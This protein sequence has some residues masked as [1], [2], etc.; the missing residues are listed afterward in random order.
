MIQKLFVYLV[1]ASV[2]ISCGSDFEKNPV[3]NLIRDLSDVPAYSI[4]LHD[5]NVEGT[6]FE[7]YFHQY[8]IV[9]I[10]KNGEPEKTT[11]DWIQVPEE[12]FQKHI[13]NMGMEIVSKSED[14]KL[15]KTAA[16]PGYS[17]FVGNEKYGRWEQNSNGSSFWQFYGQYMFMNSMFNMMAFPARRSYYDTY[18][19]D[20]YGRRPYYG[21]STSTGGRTYG[22]G[23]TYTSRT[24][25]GSNWKQKMT[26]SSFKNRVQNSVSR[27]NSRY[28]GS[29]SSSSGSM[30]SRG[31]GFGK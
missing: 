29:S 4:I 6:V 13:D 18:R 15:S 10:N 11:T 17:N 31:G 2:F 21:P 26:N 20:Y 5:M 19:T 23:S 14:G 1:L 22:T 24:S 30:R 9:K 3:D 7:D 28:S 8:E 25:T 12:V 16:P 27:S